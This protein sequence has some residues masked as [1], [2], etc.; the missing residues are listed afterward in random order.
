MKEKSVPTT[1]AEKRKRLKWQFSDGNGIV[2]PPTPGRKAVI[3]QPTPGGADLVVQTFTNAGDA[4]SNTTVN[5]GGGK[6]LRSTIV[7]LI[8]W[9]DAWNTNCILIRR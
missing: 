7:D 9:G 6:K 5:D 8:F 3:V 2:P 4:P 1:R